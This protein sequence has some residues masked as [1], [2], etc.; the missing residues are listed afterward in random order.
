MAER[1]RR[2]KSTVSGEGDTSICCSYAREAS[3]LGAQSLR[4]PRILLYFGLKS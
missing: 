1:V 4:N 2:S 3:E